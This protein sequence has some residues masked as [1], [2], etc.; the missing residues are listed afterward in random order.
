MSQQFLLI[1]LPGTGKTSFLAA[2][3]YMVNQSSVKCALELDRLDGDSKYLNELRAAWMAYKPVPRNPADTEKVVSMILKTRD[4][5]EPVRLMFPDLSG[6]SFRLQWTTR[7]FTKEYDANLRMA[8]GGI[9]FVHPEAISKPERIDAA[10]TLVE[11]MNGIEAEGDDEGEEGNVA[12]HT[13][14]EIEIAPTQVKLVELLQFISGRDYFKAPFRIAIV[15]SA[16]DLI[17]KSG[18]SPLEWISDELPLFRQ[19]LDCNEKNFETT[20]YGLSAQ[21]GRY[22]SSVFAEG[23][24]KDPKSFVTRLSDGGD[25]ISAWLWSQLDADTQ[26]ALQQQPTTNDRLELI[27]IRSFNLLIANAKLY[28]EDRFKGIKLRAETWEMLNDKNLKP[29]DDTIRL[30]RS[31]LEDVYPSELSRDRLFA[32]EAHGLQEKLPS[33]RISIVGASV[34]NPHDIT[35]PIQWLMR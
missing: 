21:G 34:K 26:S 32:K 20:F 29:G 35:E 25:P 10:D 1:G 7:Q 17:A 23:H 2:L 3:W 9:V 11:T 14:W 30:N 5:Q 31:L 33:R 18:A 13:P 27:L 19:F 6:E 24:F 28:D 8:S 4:S 15:V 12:V 16:W 22:E